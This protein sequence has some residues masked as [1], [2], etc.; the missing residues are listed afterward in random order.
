MLVVGDNAPAEEGVVSKG[1]GRDACMDGAHVWARSCT[2]PAQTY[3]NSHVQERSQVQTCLFRGAHVH[4]H[5]CAQPFL[6]VPGKPP[7]PTCAQT[8]SREHVGVLVHRHTPSWAPCTQMAACARV[9]LHVP[10]WLSTFAQSAA[11][12]VQ[13]AVLVRVCN[14]ACAH[15]PPAHAHVPVDTWAHTEAS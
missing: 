12:T 14:C 10:A 1:V 2:L 3:G 7:L 15:S 11:S 6:H 5:L 9:C 8:F 13:V 4:M